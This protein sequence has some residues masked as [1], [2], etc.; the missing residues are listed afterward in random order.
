MLISCSECK[1]QYDVGEL[2]PGSHV[3]CHCGASV[4]VPVVQRRPTLVAHCASC[5]GSVKPSEKA[6]G[7]CGS[8]VAVADSQVG[9]ICPECFRPLLRGAKFCSGCG[10]SIAA[11]RVHLVRT[12]MDCPRCEGTLRRRQV[13][14][15]AIGECLGCGGLWIGQDLLDT[16]LETKERLPEIPGIDRTEWQAVSVDDVKY[17][18]CPVCKEFMHR[19]NFG[20][21]SGVVIDWCKGHGFWFDRFEL[22]RVLEFVEKGGLERARAEE[23]KR[24]AADAR[25]RAEKRADA[26]KD[27]AAANMR[28]MTFRGYGS[29]GSLDL[30]DL[31]GSLVSAVGSLFKK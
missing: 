9:N 31:I 28:E 30:F 8:A 16:I 10:V 21:R 4:T 1:H 22:D 19:K 11:E 12:D 7:F 25:L 17:V 20:R 23:E 6:C 29:S 2:E 27:I 5:G 26:K 3:S 13:Q 14:H 18:A 24:K 15:G